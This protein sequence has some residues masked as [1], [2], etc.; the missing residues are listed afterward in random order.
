MLKKEYQK[1]AIG[2]RS[3]APLDGVKKIPYK[4][5]EVMSKV[6]KTLHVEVYGTNIDNIAKDVKAILKGKSFNRFT[7]TGNIRLVPQ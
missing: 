5:G 2:L 3:K 6:V 4:L 1:G 7:M